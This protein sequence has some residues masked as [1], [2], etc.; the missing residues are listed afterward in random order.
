[1]NRSCIA[2]ICDLRLGYIETP[3]AFESFG[4]TGNRLGGAAGRRPCW[5]GARTKSFAREFE[6][7]KRLRRV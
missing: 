5:T 3:E 4:G 1:M 2:S 6:A 7:G